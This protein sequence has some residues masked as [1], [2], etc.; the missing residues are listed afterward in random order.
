MSFKL[1]EN[2]EW[3]YGGQGGVS[4][5]IDFYINRKEKKFFKWET[6][7][8][9]SA[10]EESTEPEMEEIKPEVSLFED[11]AIAI[12][13][14]HYNKVGILVNSPYTVI[15]NIF[16]TFSNEEA[17]I[18]LQKAVSNIPEFFDALQKTYSD[19]IKEFNYHPTETEKPRFL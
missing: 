9:S 15:Q 16:F 19:L 17:K 3:I 18:E 13:L 6:Y 8:F 4:A 2:L 14:E 1:D 10:P 7:C 12:T 11:A 5:E